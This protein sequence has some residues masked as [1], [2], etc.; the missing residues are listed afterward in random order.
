MS[1]P[2]AAS[3]AQEIHPVFHAT[4]VLLTK[5]WNSGA[6][7]AV[8]RRRLLCLSLGRRRAGRTER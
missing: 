5:A 3:L 6:I 8:G 1:L 2:R 7:L 4:F